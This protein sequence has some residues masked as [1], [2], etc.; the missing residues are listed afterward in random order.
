MVGVRAYGNLICIASYENNTQKFEQGA[1]KL[2]SFHAKKRD[3]IES[4]RRQTLLFPDCGGSPHRVPRVNR[5]W[6]YAYVSHPP[7]KEEN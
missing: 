2:I 6:P 1:P 4:K 3:D 7:K 5:I